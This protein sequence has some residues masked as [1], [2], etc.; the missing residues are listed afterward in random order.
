MTVKTQEN[1][2]ST[3]EQVIPE[4][5]FTNGGIIEVKSVDDQLIVKGYIATTHPDA[6]KDVI[7]KETLEKWAKEINDG[8]PRANKVTYHHDR[9][10]VRVVGVG[11]KGTARVEQLPDGHYGLYAETIVNKSHDS[12]EVI[13]YEYSIGALDSFSIEYL[14]TGGGKEGEGRLLQEDNTDLYGWTLASRPVNEHCVMVKEILSKSHSPRPSSQEVGVEDTK[15]SEQE[16]T[17]PEVSEAQLKELAELKEYKKK[18]DAQKKKQEEEEAEKSKSEQEEEKMAAMKKEIVSELLESKEFN[19]KLDSEAEK[20]TMENKEQEQLSVEYKE[21]VQAVQDKELAPSAKLLA[22]VTYALKEGLLENGTG[23]VESRLDSKG[24]DHVQANGTKLQVK[25][26]GLGDNLAGSSSATALAGHRHAD[27][28]EALDAGIFNLLNDNVSA[29]DALPKTSAVGSGSD[30]ASFVVR[31]GR[32]PTAGAYTGNEI[33][34]GKT[35]KLKFSTRFKKYKAGFAVD[36]DL[37]AANRGAPQGAVLA[38]EIEFATLD[39]K[40]EINTDLY[41]EQ[42]LESGAKIIGMRYI[43]DSAGNTTLYGETRSSAN[44]LAPASAG[45]TYIDGSVGSLKDHLRTAIK[46]ITVDGGQRRTVRIFMHPTQM[47]R[48][49]GE[50]DNAL[51]YEPNASNVGFAPSLTFE[52]V[53][54]VEDVDCPEASIFTADAASV[55]L[56]FWVTPTVEMLGRRSDSEEGFVKAY[57]ASIYKAPRRVVELHSVPTS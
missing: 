27:L 48:L 56:R 23:K 55:E 44:G 34:T 19:A 4:S 37:I 46:N 35:N 3:K 42:G 29:Y 8:V 20:P 26:Y 43:A 51:R 52:G 15:M 6:V 13:E 16:K 38:S 39:M 9:N 54:V 36:G 57:L 53:P 10:D 28:V 18:M 7:P 17:T 31:N 1:E 5:R 25:S 14:H 47:Q 22:S 12:Y 49:K 45:D 33:T 24:F 50:E 40:K 41:T 32:N 30:H 11:L 2:S 21:Y